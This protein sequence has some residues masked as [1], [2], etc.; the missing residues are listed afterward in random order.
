MNDKRLNAEK[1]RGTGQMEGRTPN[2]PSR[3]KPLYGLP[4][5]S[6]SLRK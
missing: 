4:K 1:Q 2:L 5:G 6:V 3:R